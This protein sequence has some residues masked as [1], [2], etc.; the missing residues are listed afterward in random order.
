MKPNPG[1]I[2]HVVDRLL[3][4]SAVANVNIKPPRVVSTENE[5]DI[6]EISSYDKGPDNT[7]ESSAISIG[8]IGVIQPLPMPASTFKRLT[9][10]KHFRF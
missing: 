6:Q 5:E 4:T 10:Y 8:T 1:I 7:G 2:M 9:I 3:S